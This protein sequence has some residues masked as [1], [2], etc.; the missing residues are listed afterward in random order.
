[1]DIIMKNV[2]FLHSSSELY[3]SDKSLFNLISNL[4][5]KMYN[6]TVILPCEGPLVDKLKS[7]YEVNVIVKKIAVLRRKNF[8]F[9]GV[10]EYL[11]DFLKSIKFIISIIN[12]F[13]IDII[14]T[15]TSVVFPGAVSAKLLRKKSVWHIREIISNRIE[16]AFVSLMVD[17]FSDVIIANSN[18]T[19]KAISKNKNKVK[20]VYNAIKE[21]KKSPKDNGSKENVL[22]VGM[23]GRINRWKGQKLFI[24]MAEKVTKQYDNVNFLIAGS[25]FQGEELLEEELKEYIIKKGLAER[26]KM[27][28][29]V[30]NMSDFYNKLDIFVLPSIEPEPF[31]LVVIEAM[32]SNIPVIATNH[33][34]PTEIIENGVDGY[35]VD[36]KSAEEMSEKVMKLIENDKLRNQMAKNG[37]IKRKTTFTIE[38]YTKQISD[39]ISNIT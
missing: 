13:N 10:C 8:N 5:K 31:G 23:A 24:D 9:V 27:I 2:L 30:N 4:D 15:N 17:L 12:K 35:L 37:M 32:D 22:Y 1:M 38:N 36:F 21:C 11:I 3:G 29:Q 14:Y 25:A 19:G 34:G 28:G 7:I 26:V 6:I 39:I 33:G 20:I 16:K 18:A